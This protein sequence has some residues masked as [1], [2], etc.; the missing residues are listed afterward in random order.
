M[1]SQQ[2]DGMWVKA[3]VVMALEAEIATLRQEI[4]A[5]A[6]S[7]T[8]DVKS[9][10]DALIAAMNEITMRVQEKEAAEA[11]NVRLRAAVDDFRR[12]V[13]SSQRNDVGDRHQF[14]HAQ[15]RQIAE[16]AVTLLAPPG[17]RP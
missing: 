5:R 11:E 1:S 13:E 16:T 2:P 14:W 17:D 4:H 3:E 15:W 6:V 10:A 12:N 8:Q 9:L 7:H